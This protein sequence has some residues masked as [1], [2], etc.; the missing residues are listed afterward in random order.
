MAVTKW[1]AGLFAAAMTVA[2]PGAAMAV[3]FG[4]QLTISGDDN[5]PTFN[6]EN[7][8]GMGGLD[9]TNFVLQIKENS[10]ARAIDPSDSNFNLLSTLTAT[11]GTVN[12]PTGVTHSQT[13]D[14][15]YTDFQ[16]G[17]THTFTL[18][19]DGPNNGDDL[20]LDYWE[21]L[22][23]NGADDNAMVTVTFAGG[24][25]LMLTMPDDTANLATYT[26]SQSGD[27]MQTPEPA[28]L[29]LLGAGLIGLGMVR[30]RS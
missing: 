27:T 23:N 16:A 30:R 29:G 6:L 7:T 4:Y 1:G 8:G 9:I 18:D 21:I 2:L 26:F 17:E 10:P 11:G 12:S 22:F 15:S 3:P 19:H 13:V 24:F 20:D 25:S 14:F 5:V 28:M